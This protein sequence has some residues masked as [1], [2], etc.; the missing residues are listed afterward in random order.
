MA[1]TGVIVEG[2]KWTDVRYNLG[3]WI[4]YTY[5]GIK[6]DEGKEERG[7]SMMTPHS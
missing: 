7:I 4:T 3:C 2:E 1:W 6:T 5:S